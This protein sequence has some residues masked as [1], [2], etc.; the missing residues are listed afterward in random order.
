MINGLWAAIRFLTIIP[1]PG[2]LGAEEKDL[3]C[4]MP[5]FP[6]IGVLIGCCAAL[7]YACSH[8][9]IPVPVSS[10]L[11]VAFLLL[12]SGGFHL[13]GLADTADGLLSSR[14]KEKI[15]E[16]MR[17][18][19]IGTMGV[20]AILLNLAVKV[21]AFASLSYE[22]AIIAAFLMPICGRVFL[23]VHP[24]IFPYA[25][26]EGGLADPFFNSV[27]W[28][29]ACWSIAV[30]FLWAWI[31]GGYLGLFAALLAT[32][33][34]F[35]FGFWSNGKIGGITGD[36]LGATCELAETTIVLAM[37]LDFTKVLGS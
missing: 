9:F 4:S 20:M 35:L 26:K 24:V 13:D 10:V 6:I 2:D 37:C 15:L 3:H 29:A 34:S 22:N 23:V 11:L 12:I 7:F 30:L 32:G 19:H 21:T 31:F 16:I 33:V 25:R 27:T 28:G 14:P 17:D 8:S 36:T 18:S 1:L 5:F